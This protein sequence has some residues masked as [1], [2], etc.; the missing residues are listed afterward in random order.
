MTTRGRCPSPCCRATSE[1]PARQLALL[2]G[3]LFLLVASWTNCPIV[4]FDGKM[5]NFRID[6][7]TSNVQRTWNSM[8]TPS[9]GH[10]HPTPQTDVIQNWIS[11]VIQNEKKMNCG[12]DWKVSLI[13]SAPHHSQETD[14]NTLY[15][16]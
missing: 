7:K 12:L 9:G 1:L 14:N 2:P 16:R 3:S 13:S 10:H 5:K 15:L 4:T 8:T 6:G 11:D